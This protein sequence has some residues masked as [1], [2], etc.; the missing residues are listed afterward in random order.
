MIEKVEIL[1]PRMVKLTG[2]EEFSA[3]LTGR[4]ITAVGRRGKYLR[5]ALDDGNELIIHL[6]MTGE[7]FYSVDGRAE[8]MTHPRLV[9]RLKGGQAL[10]YGDVRTFGALYAVRPEELPQ[11]KGLYQL[12]PEPLS[13][14]FTVEYLAKKAEKSRC[15]VKSFILNQNIIGG[16]GNIYADEALFLARL[17]PEQL[18]LSLTKGELKRLHEAANQ[19][20]GDGILD[21][22]TS[23]R[24]YRDGAGNKGSHQEKLAVYQRTGEP[25]VRCGTPLER[26][27]VG[28]R[29]THFC[30]RCQVKK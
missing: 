30:P 29:G 19:V 20:I 15:K 4:T 21:G 16:L 13:D 28:G 22:G 17:H 7:L 23:F 26:I 25:C 9:F 8:A 12:G 18:A 24:N 10:F 27:V 1:L 5:F 14:E 11:I 3:R 2:P 6:R